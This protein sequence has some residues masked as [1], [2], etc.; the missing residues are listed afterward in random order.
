MLLGHVKKSDGNR[1]TLEISDGDEFV[2]D[3]GKS[4]T[5]PT[6]WSFKKV[7]GTGN[8]TPRRFVIAVD[9]TAVS[10]LLKHAASFRLP[11]SRQG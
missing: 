7:H 8:L 10:S 5:M 11:T 1:G 6:E 4:Q 2:H 9:I 3:L